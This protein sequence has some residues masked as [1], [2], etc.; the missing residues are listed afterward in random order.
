MNAVAVS[1]SRLP[2]M[3]IA[4]CFAVGLNT[5][6]CVFALGVMARMG[7][8]A[9]PVGLGGVDDW[10][11]MGVCGFLFAGEFVADK[12]PGFDVIWNLLHTF[13]RIP[14]AG[15]LA[16]AAGSPLPVGMRM[17]VTV[18]GVG[19][20][21]AAHGS[22]TA[23]RVAVMPSPE[24]VSNVALSLGEDGVAV[25]LGWMAM[26]HPVAG[27][28]LVVGLTVGAAGLAWWG[29]RRIRVGWARRFRDRR[30]AGGWRAPRSDGETV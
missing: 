6:G 8:V 2:A 14:V 10:W 28:V 30:V 18:V 3:V 17:V 5:Y 19:F 12:I 1:S 21:A 11:V 22:K 26:R 27:G 13:V 23:L 25:G 4:L 16:F 20:A 29:V 9:L 24:P 7:W 15:V